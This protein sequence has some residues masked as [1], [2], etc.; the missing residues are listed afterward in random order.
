MFSGK[1]SLRDA[2]CSAP[3]IQT[4]LLP[5]RLSRGAEAVWPRAPP[6]PVKREVW[7][8]E[9]ESA[10]F[11]VNVKDEQAVKIEAPIKVERDPRQ[12]CVRLATVSIWQP[13]SAASS[14]SSDAGPS[15]TAYRMQALRRIPSSHLGPADPP[16]GRGRPKGSKSRPRIPLTFVLSVPPERA[17][18]MEARKS[19]AMTPQ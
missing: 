6:R 7:E 9:A 4:S 18:S 12:L 10:E 17:A 8:S 13:T 5:T 2:Y 16:Q 3:A 19:I 15:G 11:V 14:S 1:L